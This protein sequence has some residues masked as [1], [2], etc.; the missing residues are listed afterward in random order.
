MIILINFYG[1]VG[2]AIV[3][4]ILNAGYFLIEIPIMHGR[5]LKHDMWRWYFRDVAMPLIVILAIVALSRMFIP[6]T[7][8]KPLTLAWIASTAFIALI[9]SSLVVPF[10]RD[11]IKRSI[12]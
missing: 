3:W 9:S 4:I 7:I 11:L 1:A 10:T 8:S 12:A 2:A 5:V 6:Q